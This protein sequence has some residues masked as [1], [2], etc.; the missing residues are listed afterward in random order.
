MS[1]KVAKINK[2]VLQISGVRAPR[3]RDR[4]CPKV[5]WGL[6]LTIRRPDWL[7]QNEEISVGGEPRERE[8]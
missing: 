1:K 4:K 5:V 6:G 2:Q 8:A 3:Q 7:E